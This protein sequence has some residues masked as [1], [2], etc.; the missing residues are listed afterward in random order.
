MDEPAKESPG[1]GRKVA[2]GG[3][4]AMSKKE[5]ELGEAEL[6]V[7]RVLWDQGPLTVREVM[8]VLHERGR[9]VAYTTVLTF[10]T[11]LEQKGFVKADKGD[12]AYIYRAKASRA[13]VTKSRVR[14]L[15]DEL[16]DGAAGPVVLHLVEN[17]RLTPGEIDQLRRLMDE[18]DKK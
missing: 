1:A 15:L 8:E 9:K 18:L 6:G 10:L 4:K 2:R 5:H 7:L 13:S 11:R 14:A 17:E 16:Y 12:Q 3:S